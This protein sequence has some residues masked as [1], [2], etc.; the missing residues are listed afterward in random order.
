MPGVPLSSLRL[1]VERIQTTERSPFADVS[2]YGKY[3]Y[4]QTSYKH[5]KAERVGS[6]IYVFGKI[7]KA[8]YVVHSDFI[9]V[10]IAVLD[11]PEARWR[12]I[13]V[14][15]PGHPGAC[16]FLYEDGIYWYG[17]SDDP[18]LEGRTQ[19]LFRLD[20]VSEEFCGI[21]DAGENPDRRIYATGSYFERRKQFIVFG[22]SIQGITP[23]RLVGDVKIL[24]MPEKVWSKPIIKGRTPS[25]RAKHSASIYG[26]VLYVY[27]GVLKRGRGDFGIY[28][29]HLQ[30]ASRA[31]WSRPKTNYRYLRPHLR[32][33]LSMLQFGNL[34]FLCKGNGQEEQTSYCFDKVKS[35]FQRVEGDETSQQI[36]FAHAAVSWDSGKSFIFLGGDMHGLDCYYKGRLV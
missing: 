21:V 11:V 1:Q 10:T 34:I 7:R 12:W 6:H 18:E 22:G 17:S 2:E 31:R 36:R 35:E 16:T 25:P 20:L 14:T 29:L 9:R 27:G 24:N 32:D 4:M 8:G 13:V 26:N 3:L 23:D 19:T 30:S 33:S 28:L 15:G 5:L